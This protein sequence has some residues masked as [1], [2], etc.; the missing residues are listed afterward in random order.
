VSIAD[1]N[2]AGGDARPDVDVDQNATGE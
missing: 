2:V 1:R